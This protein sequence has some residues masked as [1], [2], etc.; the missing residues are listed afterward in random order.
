MKKFFF[1]VLVLVSWCSISYAQNFHWEWCHG[2]NI[3]GPYLMGF[4]RNGD[5]VVSAQ[6]NWLD[7]SS[8]HGG[9]WKPVALPRFY[10]TAA[11]IVFTASSHILV[12]RVTPPGYGTTEDSALLVRVSPDG[13][14]VEAISRRY[15]TFIS[16]NTRGV[17]NAIEDSSLLLESL[18]EGTTWDTIATPAGLTL[19]GCVKTDS[20][21]YIIATQNGLYRNAAL[22]PLWQQV[23]V[24]TNDPN[25]QLQADAYGRI[26]ITND[27]YSTDD[28]VTWN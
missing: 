18:D 23:L 11:Q 25:L 21:T 15:L 13:T 16:A 24:D 1:S 14:D 27:Q 3:G 26:F 28:G 20:G 5:L 7:L 19:A 4:N 22:S 6:D 8:D 17:T 2:P 12:L 9:S 10:Y